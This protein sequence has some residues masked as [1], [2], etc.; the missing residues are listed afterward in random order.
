MANNKATIWGCSWQ[1]TTT[2]HQQ[3]QSDVTWLR[4][5]V[6]AMRLFLINN[7]RVPTATLEATILYYPIEVLDIINDVRL[8]R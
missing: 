3:I 7:L 4:D 8:H 6:D 5:D 2:R 1:S